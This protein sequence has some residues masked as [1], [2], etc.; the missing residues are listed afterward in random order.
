[1][2]REREVSSSIAARYLVFMVQKQNA[3]IYDV[4]ITRG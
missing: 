2:L 1:M 3:E 4:V